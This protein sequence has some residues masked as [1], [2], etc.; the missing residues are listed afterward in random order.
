MTSDL[1]CPN[2]G[3]MGMA[4]FYEMNGAP[5]HSVQ[6]LQSREQ[7]G[8]YPSG[9]IKLAVCPNCAF[10]ANVAY[11]PRL[12]DYSLQYEATQ[13]YSPTFNHFH[14]NLAQRLIARYDLHDKEIIEIG[15]GHGEFLILLC[16]AGPNKG[17]GFDPAYDESR[18]QHEAKS[19]ITFIADYYSEEY[20]DIKGDFICCKMTL[21]HIPNTAEFVRTVRRS[22]G[23]NFDTTIFFQIPNASYVLQDV[24]FWDV[25]YEHCSYFTRAS[26]TYLFLHSGFDVLDVFTGYDE[27]YLMIEAR[28]TNNLA[29]QRS[30]GPNVAETLEQ[31]DL[32][33]KK[34]LERLQ[35]WRDLLSDLRARGKKVVIWGSG[36]KGVAFLT[37]LNVTSDI[38]YAVDINPHKHGTFMAGTGHEIVGPDFLRD[39]QPDTV[40]VM[41]PVYHNEIQDDLNR[42]GLSANLIMVDQPAPTTALDYD[43]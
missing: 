39:Y 34:V 2:C 40:I 23:D 15:C 36:S 21:E 42:L 33:S 9:A 3:V 29:P 37:T 5:V 10:I 13:S 7:A 30:I 27:Q 22:I 38:A 32:F 16:E 24:A 6:L 11:D 4:P 41:N 20:A 12:Q 35:G 25:Y 19:R 1:I 31:V 17:V 14:R 18:I 43:R 28:P 8:S 26:L